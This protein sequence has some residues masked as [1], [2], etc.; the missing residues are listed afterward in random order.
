MK[1]DYQNGF[2]NHFASEA[3]AG[4]L[5][6]GRNSPQ[7]AAHGLYA[8]LL[9]GTAFTAP[10]A[11]NRRSWMYRRLPSAATGAYQPYAQPHWL[12]GAAG[13]VAAPPDPMRWHPFAIPDAP[14]DFVDGLRTVVANGDADAQTGMAALVYGANRSMT[15]RALV[16]ADGEMLL[17]PQQGRLR[18]TTEL[19]RARSQPRRDR[20]AA[21]RPGFQGRVARRPF[22]RLRRRKLRRAVAPARTRPHRQ[23]RPGQCARL[24]GAGGGVRERGRR[25]R[26]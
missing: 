1:L 24:S 10:R 20:A 23:Q 9:S 7:R 25:L 13:G 11:D 22:T 4:A 21:A 15:Q 2:G 14:T 17:V 5:P 3:V 19:G 16:N 6:Q 26:D 8:E 18:I 12:T